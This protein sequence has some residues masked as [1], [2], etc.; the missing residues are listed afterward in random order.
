M[1]REHASVNVVEYVHFL[2][3]RFLDAFA[4]FRKSTVWFAMSPSVSS[5]AMN[6]IHCS[7]FSEF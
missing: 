1:I 3:C 7:E 5:F 6:N 4:K 2:S